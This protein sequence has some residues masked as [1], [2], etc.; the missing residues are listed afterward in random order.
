MREQRSGVASR[1][2]LLLG[3]EAVPVGQVGGELPRLPD[4]LSAYDSRNAGLLVTAIEE[5]RESLDR[6]ISKYGPARVAVVLGTST[7]GLAEGEK[8]FFQALRAGHLPPDF[9]M[10]RQELGSPG[11]VAARYL[12]LQGPAFTV[13]TACSSGAQAL[14]DGRRLLRAGLADA[15]LV[16]GVDSLCR[17]TVN[18][19]QALSALS[20][21]FCNP[22]SRNRDGTMI[23][24]GAAVFLMQRE[25]S[26][27]ALQGVGASCDAHSMTAPDPA[28]Q[29][30]MLSMRSAIADAGVEPN[31]IAFI[32]LHGTGTEQNDAM[33]S[34]AVLSVFGENVPCSSSKGRVGHTLGAAGAMGAAHCWLTASTMNEAG[35][36]PPHI[37]D[38][39]AEAGL[40]DRSLVLPGQRLGASA[41]RV[42]L[43][44]ALAF[45]G[46]NVSLV[47][48]RG[49]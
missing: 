45:G 36:L 10:R 21:G 27:I 49:A 6:A 32:E 26:E 7:S 1:E 13:S 28:A 22:F 46:N 16:G 24:E 44:N 31:E 19:F 18:G 25:E 11:E 39:E 3:G 29:G 8:A 23:G 2:D 14:A 41:R 47:I 33:E 34:K 12:G 4:A 35:H 17:L 43:C 15:V 48:G 9:D 5:L 37:W 30:V 20:K 40:L 42:F 38:G